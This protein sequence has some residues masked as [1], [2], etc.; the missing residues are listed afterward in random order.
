MRS[1]QHLHN[2]SRKDAIVARLLIL[3]SRRDEFSFPAVMSCLTGTLTVDMTSRA[4]I[5]LDV[6]RISFM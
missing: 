3:L 5:P 1:F 4:R 2:L 6:I